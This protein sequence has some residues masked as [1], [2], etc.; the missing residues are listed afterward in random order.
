MCN[1]SFAFFSTVVE[2]L[3]CF[4]LHIFSLSTKD[5]FS[6]LVNLERSIKD[7]NKVNVEREYKQGGI[8]V[9]SQ[10]LSRGLLKQPL[11]KHQEPITFG[12]KVWFGTFAQS[13]L[14]HLKHH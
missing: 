12:S 6:F 10:Q 2:I 1:Y 4:D 9:T 11:K 5:V 8:I 14:S 7:N 13:M 3:I